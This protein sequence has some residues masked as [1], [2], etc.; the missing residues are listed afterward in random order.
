MTKPPPKKTDL[1]VQDE[2]EGLP[3]PGTAVDL[4]ARKTIR[5][6]GRVVRPST[7]EIRYEVMRLSQERNPSDFE[8]GLLVA[9]EWTMGERKTLKRPGK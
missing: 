6:S 2:V 3:G 1:P 7:A 9:L 8:L 4:E 5:E